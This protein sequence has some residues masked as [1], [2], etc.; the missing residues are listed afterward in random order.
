MRTVTKNAV[1]FPLA[2]LLI[3]AVLLSF[4]FLSPDSAAAQTT[5]YEIVYPE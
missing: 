5:D 4:V 2:M 1:I 3:A